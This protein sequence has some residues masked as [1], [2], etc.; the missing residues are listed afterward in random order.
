MHD[1]LNAVYDAGIRT[2]I[3][4]PMSFNDY[5]TPV[6]QIQKAFLPGQKKAKLGVCGDYSVTVNPQLETHWHPIPHPEDLMWK[7]GG[8]C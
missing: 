1:D 7:L 8:G 3:W 5:G 2:G 4:V 6:M